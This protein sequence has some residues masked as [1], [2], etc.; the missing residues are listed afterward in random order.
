MQ[1]YTKY[2]DRMNLFLLNRA[3]AL[4][5]AGQDQQTAYDVCA[6]LAQIGPDVACYGKSSKLMKEV[7]AQVRSDI[8]GE[9]TSLNILTYHQRGLGD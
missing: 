7:K 2:L 6:M 5:A 4:W 8:M 1:L 9:S 3:K